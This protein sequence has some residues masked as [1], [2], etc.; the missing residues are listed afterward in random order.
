MTTLSAISR[1]R[2]GFCINTPNERGT[3]SRH[4]YVLKMNHAW[5][6]TSTINLLTAD[7]PLDAMNPHCG[8]SANL[9]IEEVRVL[10]ELYP[11]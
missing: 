4:H 1:E 8:I 10:H 11:S 9:V 3:I 5:F 2:E 7:S 6:E